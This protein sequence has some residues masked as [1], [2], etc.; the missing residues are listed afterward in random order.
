MKPKAIALCRVS[1]QGQANDGNLVPQEQN[2]RKSADILEADLV[3]IWSLAASSRKGKNLKRKDLHE[4]RDY[5]KRYKSV[6]YLIIDEADR[7]MRSIDEYY[8]WKVEFKVLGV[9]IRFTKDPLA[10]PEDDTAIFNELIDAY[11]AESSNNERIKKTPDKQRNK[12]LAGYYP[13]NPHTG[14][15]RSDIPSLHVPDEPNWSAMRNAFKAMAAGECDITE[16]LKRATEDGLRTRNYGPKAVGGR[17]IDMNRWKDLM[18]DPYYWGRLVFNKSSPWDL[19]EGL[20]GL[21]Q[22]MI[23]KEEHDNLV[24]IVKNKG[25]LFTPKRDNPDFPLANIAE[26]SYCLLAGCKYPRLTGAWGGNGKKNSTK[27]YRRYYCRCKT[28]GC[29]LGVRQEA[30]HE[31]VS[32]E[33]AKL[34]L[35]PEQHEKLKQSLRKIWTSHEKTLIER[36]YIADGRLE[37]LKNN[38]RTMVNSY[39]I[40]TDQ[41]MKSDLKERIEEINIEIIEAEKIAAEA[42]DFEKDFDEFIE[43]AFDFTNNKDR[44]IWDLDKPTLKVYKQLVFPAG[45]QVTQDKKVYNPSVSP[46]YTF[47]KQKT[48][49]NEA[50]SD[51]FVLSGGP[52]GTR[53]HDT[54]LKRQVL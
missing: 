2:V 3:R 37:V 24:R 33:L 32:Q 48:P 22:P 25:K 18:T 45:I 52:S 51:D 35:S 6:K 27:R 19:P 5:C 36:A 39:G 28:C 16:G 12:I 4:M 23:T 29:T 53:T 49:Q 50:L 44:K 10:D 1:T 54:L 38:K 21:H 13:S 42:H 15:K 14:Y 34:N 41:S 47:K 11:R 43:F 7:F 8:W 40:E 30:L 20:I 46:I 9:Q 26:C 17:K 31:G